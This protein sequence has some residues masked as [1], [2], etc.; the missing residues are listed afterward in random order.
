MKLIPCLL[1]TS[2]STIAF[3]G[4]HPCLPTKNKVLP[5]DTTV[6]IYQ[7]AKNKKIVYVPFVLM[8]DG[9]LTSARETLLPTNLTIFNMRDNKPMTV[10]F[11]NVH[12]NVDYDVCR[13]VGKAAHG[14]KA[15]THELFATQPMAGSFVFQ[16]GKKDVEMFD[17]TVQLPCSAKHS[18]TYCDASQLIATSE[19]LG[20]KQYWHTKQY[21][22][23]LGF[24][25]GVLD[26]KTHQLN[27][28]VEDCAV[29]A[30]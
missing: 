12:D 20:Q 10:H 24:G 5:K 25:I 16:L 23:D 14:E 21:R 6:F 9:K 26:E 3:A 19:L 22:Y 4:I 13:S 1:L 7:T 29:C 30:D 11:Q 28:I 18:I 17:A 27:E 8:A 2:Y 15:N